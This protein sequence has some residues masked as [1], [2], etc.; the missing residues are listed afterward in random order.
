MGRPLEAAHDLRIVMEK[1]LLDDK[2]AGNLLSPHLCFIRL[3]SRTAPL[4]ALVAK[5]A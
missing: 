4:S 1:A 3:R 5:A 2:H